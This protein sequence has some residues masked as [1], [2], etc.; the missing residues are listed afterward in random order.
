[1]NKLAKLSGLYKP[2]RDS[3]AG[4]VNWKELGLCVLFAAIIGGSGGQLDVLISNVFSCIGIH[5]PV[6]VEHLD[7]A[8]IV[9]VTAYLHRKEQKA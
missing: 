2:V 1:M 6:L 7:S 5:D 8:I 9:F 3:V 4:K